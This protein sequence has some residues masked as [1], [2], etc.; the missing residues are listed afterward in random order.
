MAVFAFAVASLAE[1]AAE[2]AFVVAFCAAAVASVASF[3]TFSKAAMASS[4]SFCLCLSA[5]A[6]CVSA[7]FLDASAYNDRRAI[8]I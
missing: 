6:R 4:V 3:L 5:S 1:V 7:V 8:F 2:L